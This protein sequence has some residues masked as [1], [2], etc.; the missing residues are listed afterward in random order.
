V[1]RHPNRLPFFEKA[2]HMKHTLTALIH[3]MCAT[4]SPA[5][6]AHT[7]YTGQFIY[8]NDVQL[9]NFTVGAESNVTF[10]PLSDAGGVNAAGQAIARGGF[11]PI[12]TLFNAAGMLIGEQ[13]DSNCG[14]VGTDAVTRQCWDISLD[15]KL[16]AGNYTAAIQQYNNYTVSNN[17]ADGFYFAGAANQNFRN[18]F[19]D[20]MDNKR[21]GS[22]A[23]DILNVNAA[24]VVP[25]DVPEPASLALFGA[26]LAGM[27][28]LRR[29][30]KAM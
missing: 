29:R 23:F 27:A 7:T 28:T 16:A 26:A 22:W 12:F 2:K 25:V 30:R 15:L 20:E 6:A 8:D 17:L 24:A 19:V 9:F 1:S 3:A 14:R 11:D 10:R 13:D 5:S 21:N 4:L 18:G